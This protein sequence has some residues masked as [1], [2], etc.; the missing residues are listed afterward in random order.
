MRHVLDVEANGI[1]RLLRPVFLA[2]HDA[3]VEDLEWHAVHRVLG[4]IG[5]VEGRA[6]DIVYSSLFTGVHGNYLRTSILA[7]GLDPDNLPEGD[8][9]TMDF[10][11]G[12]SA[13]K[14][15]RDIWGAGQGVGLMDEVATVAEVVE[16]LSSEY[17]AARQR[18]LRA[19]ADVCLAVEFAHSRGI[20][21]DAYAGRPGQGSFC[22]LHRHR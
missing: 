13:K 21:H 22:R 5:I 16:R 1:Y 20:I 6:S 10:G 11:G 8:I 18:L 9:K 17:A 12:E 4:V 19:F 3:L 14:A 2:M 7:S 15:W